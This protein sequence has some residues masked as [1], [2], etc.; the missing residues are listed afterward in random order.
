VTALLPA[1]AAR[2]FAAV[3]GSAPMVMPASLRLAA[4]GEVALA[5]LGDASFLIESPGG[6]RIVTDYNGVNRPGL[7]SDIVTMNH[8]HP[9]HCT[10]LVDPGVKFVLR[11]R[12]GGNGIAHHDLRNQIRRCPHPMCRPTS[13]TALAPS[14]GGN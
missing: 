12:D 2:C 7:I 6:V 8:A 13:A 11:G 1:L 5:F 9:S 3:A 4:A 14:F 10:E